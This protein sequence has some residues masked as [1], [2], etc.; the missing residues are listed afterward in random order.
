MSAFSASFSFPLCVFGA[1]RLR[2]CSRNV[3]LLLLVLVLVL[4]L[5]TEVAASST[6][7]AR[8][9]RTATSARPLL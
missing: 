9:L 6:I 2:S 3:T 4:V 5:A 7:A 8:L 1:S